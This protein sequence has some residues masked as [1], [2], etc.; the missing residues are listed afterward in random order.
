MFVTSLCTH[1]DAPLGHAPSSSCCSVDGI[2]TRWYPEVRHYC[3]DVPFILVGVTDSTVSTSAESTHSATDGN[4][5]N[6]TAEAVSFMHKKGLAV[7]RKIRAARYLECDLADPE[8]V[9]AVFYEAVRSSDVF[10]RTTST[11]PTDGSSCTLQ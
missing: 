3:P 8:S 1:S 10:K 4:D 11:T 9:R 7:A 5:N 6:I 2:I